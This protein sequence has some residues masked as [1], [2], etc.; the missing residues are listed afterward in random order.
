MTKPVVRDTYVNAL[1]E[2]IKTLEHEL[3]RRPTPDQIASV[4]EYGQRQRRLYEDVLARNVILKRK[5]EERK[6]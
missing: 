3:L 1:Q 2:R 5:L 4:V 6:A